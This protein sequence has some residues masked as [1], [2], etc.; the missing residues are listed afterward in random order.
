MR[1]EDEAGIE[2]AA[3]SEDT[4]RAFLTYV[5][6]LMILVITLMLSVPLVGFALAPL[7][8]KEPS[9]WVRLARLADLTPG[10]PSSHRYS[11]TYRDGWQSKVARG[12]A[13]VITN[14]RRTFVVMSNICTHGNCAVRWDAE[15]EV[16][17]CPC[18]DGRFSREGEPVF[19]P[20]K[21]ALRQIPHKVR[22]DSIYLCFG[23]DA[24]S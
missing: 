17:Q 18:H 16:F 8:E 6:G 4:R 1:P 24:A 5:T 3:P 9:R 2:G 14:D 21:E 7:L 13:Y 15:R 20:P 11:F 22:G 19:G 10:A 12:T 23:P